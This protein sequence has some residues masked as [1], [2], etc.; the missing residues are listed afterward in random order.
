MEELF[1]ISLPSP[2]RLVSCLLCLQLY[3]IADESKVTSSTSM[4]LVLRCGFGRRDRGAGACL[5]DT[6]L[7]SNPQPSFAVPVPKPHP[8]PLGNLPT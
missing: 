7:L 1:S 2:L 8:A 6:A 3:A 5:T 4:V